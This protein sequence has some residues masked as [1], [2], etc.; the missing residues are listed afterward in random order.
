MHGRSD[1][2]M[3]VRGIRIGPAEI[4][5]ILGPFKEIQ[6]SIVV[7]QPTLGRRRFPNGAL[8][9]HDGNGHCSTLDFAPESALRSHTKHLPRISPR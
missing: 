9:S 4:Y 8:C 1:G 5:R 3:N 7:E 2:M 6:E